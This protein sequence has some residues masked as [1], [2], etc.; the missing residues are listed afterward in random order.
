MSDRG[1]VVEW[2]EATEEVIIIEE[3][4]LPNGNCS[5][6]KT[7]TVLLLFMHHLHF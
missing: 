2:V 5:A 7:S 4:L 6:G 1:D 3:C